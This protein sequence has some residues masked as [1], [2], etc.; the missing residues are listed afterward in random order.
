MKTSVQPPST[1]P[2]PPARTGPVPGVSDA[3]G[4][5]PATRTPSPVPPTTPGGGLKT[6]APSVSQP[7]GSRFRAPEAPSMEPHGAPET[8]R[9]LDKKA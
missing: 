3:V 7:A 8:R 4:A 2:S 1:A 6:P 9:R 5:S